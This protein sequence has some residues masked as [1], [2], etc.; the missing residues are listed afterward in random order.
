MVRNMEIYNKCDNCKNNSKCSYDTP[1]NCESEKRNGPWMPG[2]GTTRGNKWRVDNEELR[3]E[4]TIEAV[5][6]MVERA[7][8]SY[9][10]S[11]GDCVSYG[12]YEGMLRVLLYLETR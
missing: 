3:G 8:A 10:N 1:Q 5:N 12:I 2:G 9:A 4:Q 7:W 6:C 11:L